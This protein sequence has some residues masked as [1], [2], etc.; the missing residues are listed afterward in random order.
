MTKRVWEWEEVLPGEWRIKRS[1]NPF[2][3][4]SVWGG[5]NEGATRY[6]WVDVYYV[7]GDQPGIVGGR[8]EFRVTK[9]TASISAE[10]LRRWCAEEADK[11]LDALEG[12]FAI[13]GRSQEN[14]AGTNESEE[15][16]H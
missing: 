4:L 8:V 10:E 13:E 5:T 7:S 9:R 2:V 16:I 12:I 1:E 6:G 15:V 14:I 3:C 11:A